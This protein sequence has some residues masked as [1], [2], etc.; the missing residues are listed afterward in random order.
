VDEGQEVLQT[1]GSE[2]FS[3]RVTRKVFEGSRLKEED[4]FTT[5]YLAPPKVILVPEGTP[6][7]ETP[8][9]PE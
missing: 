4:D 3:V 9:A 1:E 8:Y 5:N 6:G 2:G 7:A